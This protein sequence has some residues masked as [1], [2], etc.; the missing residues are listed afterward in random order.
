VAESKIV[1]RDVRL[2]QKTGC[3]THIQHI[4]ARESVE[5]IRQAQR[6]GVPVTAE[7]TP[8][9]L[10]LT[11]ESAAS[12]DSNFK[13]NP[14]V[15]TEADRQALIR[16]ILDGT[17]SCFA[18]DHAPHRAVDKALGFL[19][20]PFGVIG[21]ETAIGVT[22]THL[23]AAGLMDPVTWIRRWTLGPA[24]VL[25]L[26][27]PSLAIGAVADLALLDLRQPYRVDRNAMQSK[28]RNTPFHGHTLTGR[29]VMTWMGGRLTY[30]AE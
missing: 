26:P 28:S 2:A 7:L 23:V 13:M 24:R 3:H 21:L 1:A 9:H 12:G 10:A 22:Y 25:G 20:A 16:A 15:R 18:T 11:D 27:P 29:C 19:K 4:S 30:R 17:V 6:C 5:F 14:P 8:H